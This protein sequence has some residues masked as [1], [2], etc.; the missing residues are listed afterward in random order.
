LYLLGETNDEL[1][2]SEYFAQIGETGGTVPHVDAKKNARIYD[3]VTKAMDQRLIASAIGLSR[4][5]VA[6]ALSKSA[7]AGSLGAR[8][9]FEKLLGR[10]KAADSILFSESQGR[11]L[12]SVRPEATDVFERLCKGV[13]ISRIGTVV[14][15]TNIVISVM[16]QEIDL[17]LEDLTE[18]YRSFFKEW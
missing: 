18:S 8:I 7:I 5:G 10:A 11:I 4:G 17:K 1:G 16:D 13:A 2:A 3:A 9:D 15:D 14:A 6:V 12:V